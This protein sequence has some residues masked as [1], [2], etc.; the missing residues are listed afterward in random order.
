MGPKL[1]GVHLKTAVKI[2]LKLLLQIAWLKCVLCSGLT[3]HLGLRV[4]L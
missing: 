4:L 2:E 1:S 3:L